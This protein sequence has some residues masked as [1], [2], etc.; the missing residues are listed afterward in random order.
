[1]GDASYHTVLLPNF[2]SLHHLPLLAH[3]HFSHS[4][5]SYFCN[6]HFQKQWT[7]HK[8][9]LAWLGGL[10]TWFAL[11]A[12]RLS[13]EKPT[14]DTGDSLQTTLTTTAS[15][16][17]FIWLSTHS[18]ISFETL[19][20]RTICSSLKWWAFY[21]NKLKRLRSEGKQSN[22]MQIEMRSKN[23]GD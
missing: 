11:S 2:P 12:I 14:W 22:A 19:Q 8:A 4:V 1:M 9:S 13:P 23:D 10:I 16:I 17:E 18:Q 6:L 21:V 7:D 3:C 20:K 15:S 5:R